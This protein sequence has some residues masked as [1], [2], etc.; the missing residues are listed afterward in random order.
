M[1]QS[2]TAPRAKQSGNAVSARIEEPSP[3]LALLTPEELE[4]VA[5]IPVKTFK[6]GTLLLREGQI[7]STA[8]YIIKGCVREYYL[9]DGEE[10]TVE[11]YTEDDSICY[12][13]SRLNGTPARQYMECI[14]DTTVSMCG[15]EQEKALFRRF[16]RLE[17]LCRKDLE[18][19]L[20]QYQEAMAVYMISTPAERYQH[21][22]KNRP[23]L[24]DRVPQ[25]QLASYIG[26]KPESLSRI[27]GRIRAAAKPMGSA[28][29]AM[30]DTIFS[31]NYL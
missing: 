23:G 21:L 24:L 13:M 17:S 16:P 6:K 11:F 20:A 22:I 18:A 27:R 2:D 28:A 5:C 25:Y 1:K 14:E 29:M 30:P 10:R 9:I 4:A 7:P 15:Y 3:C 12:S 19:K 26:V 8:Y 31:N